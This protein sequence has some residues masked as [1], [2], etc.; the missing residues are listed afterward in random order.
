MSF[1]RTYRRLFCSTAKYRRA[2][3]GLSRRRLVG[4]ETLDV[5]RLMAAD[6]PF[7]AAVQDTAEFL[8]GR[9]AV[10]PIFLES[11]GQTDT[12]TQ[13][14]TQ[15][16]IDEVLATLTDGINWWSRALDK[17]DTVHTL[18]FVIDDRFAKDPFETSY[19]AIDRN[20]D[21]VL[22]PVSEF[23][24]AQGVVDDPET[25]V[26]DAMFAFNH[27]QRLALET[28]WSISI[29]VVDSS[30]DLD[31]SFAPGGFPRAFA[32][33]GGLFMVSSDFDH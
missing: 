3:R 8:L 5:R 20:S 21:D 17:L 4:F 32:Y 23:L 33:P 26:G 2:E 10:T 9:V 24:V 15:E 1:R 7:G 6:V 31:G 19:E 18:D 14:W 16:E 30:D 27:G 22:L 12:E 11:N 25:S 29:V 13:N 28:D